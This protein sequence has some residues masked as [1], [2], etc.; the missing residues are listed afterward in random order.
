MDFLIFLD[1][2]VPCNEKLFR[3]PEVADVLRKDLSIFRG[4]LCNAYVKLIFYDFFMK[5]TGLK[6]LGFR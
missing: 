4:L 5:F 1:F 2:G 3:I 6:R